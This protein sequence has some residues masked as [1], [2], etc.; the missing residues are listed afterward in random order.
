MIIGKKSLSS[1]MTMII[2]CLLLVSGCHDWKMN[3]R[4]ASEEV[5][6]L[7]PMHLILVMGG[8]GI[9][10]DHE[11]VMKRANEILAEFV[12]N[13]TI[14][15]KFIPFSEYAHKFDLMMAAEEE[16]D[17]AWQSWTQSLT[18]TVNYGALLPMDDLMEDTTIEDEIPKWLLDGGKVQGQQYM[19]PKYEMHYWQLAMWTPEESFKKYFDIEKGKKVFGEANQTYIHVSQDMW[20]MYDEYLSAA[21]KDGALN[22][23]YSPWVNRMNEGI[24]LIGG[25][26]KWSYMMPATIRTYLPGHEWDFTVRNTYKL[27]ENITMFKQLALWKAKGFIAEDM[28]AMENPRKILEHSDDDTGALIWFHS[29]SN[30]LNEGDYVVEKRWK[31]STVRFPVQQYPVV[32]PNTADGL[33]IPITAK[34]PE[35]SMMVIEL[36]ETAK[37]EEFYN[38][39]V[40]GIE[41]I[42]Y[43]KE[44]ENRIEFD[45]GTYDRRSLD[46]TY[47]QAGF[48]LGNVHNRW[49]TQQDPVDDYK[50]YWNEMH[51]TGIVTPLGG[52]KYNDAKYSSEIIQIKSILSEYMKGF[53]S[54]Y[55]TEES[56][57]EFLGKLE[58]AGVDEVIADVQLQVDEYLKLEGIPR[59]GYVMN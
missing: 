38:T 56:Y 16:V 15:V 47:G 59:I 39:L 5:N 6:E 31:K 19:I 49:V 52:F 28:L 29:Y 45:V 21:E 20:D 36:L 27:E 7:E 34:D 9:Q 17:I 12:P 40:Y 26:P 42:H 53:M 1:V 24:D 55:Y 58:K 18:A 41:S 11:L 3:D 8:N 44:S 13:T 46:S 57:S 30:P 33:T 2:M 25:T 4:G 14:E 51:E 32:Q 22:G 50:P 23:G 37:G 43:T 10:K 35:R 48:V 54:G